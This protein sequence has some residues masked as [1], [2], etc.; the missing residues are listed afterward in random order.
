MLC[1]VCRVLYVHGTQGRVWHPEHF[2]CAHCHTPF[3]GSEFFEKD[4]LPYC[5]EHF[6]QL[7]GRPCSKC[8]LVRALSLSLRTRARTLG[9]HR[10]PVVSLARDPERRGGAG[11]DVAQ[12]TLLV[13]GLRHTPGPYGADL[14][15]R[16]VRK[17]TTEER[18]HAALV[19]GWVITISSSSLF[20]PL[21]SSSSSC[22]H[23]KPLCKKCYL[24][25]PSKMRAQIEKQK[26]LEAKM[27]L[28]LKKEQ[29]KELKRE[30]LEAKKAAKAA[31]KAKP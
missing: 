7:F 21:L 13:P 28:R 19:M 14:R 16:R 4:G 31:G 11:Q 1:V 25:L 3:A 8:D 26:M 6:K 22:L 29:Q 15:Q 27:A 10:V 20:F 24:K 23:R 12:G 17:A 9:H 18:I 30:Q 5:E 2:C